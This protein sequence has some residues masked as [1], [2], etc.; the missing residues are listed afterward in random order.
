M[1]VHTPTVAVIFM[2][3]RILPTFMTKV[4]TAIVRA[5]SVAFVI[6]NILPF[7]NVHCFGL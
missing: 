2:H 4:N 1:T 6:N 3:H 7:F 5:L